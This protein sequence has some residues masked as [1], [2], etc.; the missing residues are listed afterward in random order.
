MFSPDFVF[1]KVTDIQPE[2]LKEKGICALVL[3]VDNTLSIHGSQTPFEGVQ[4]WIV[5][6]KNADISLILASNNFKRRVSP[7]ARRLGLNFISMSCKPFS[8]GI[9]KALKNFGFQKSEVAIVGDQIYTDILGGN[10]AGIHSILVQPIE[11][12]R[13]I[14]FRIKR[15]M[16][17]PVIACYYHKK[18]TGG[19]EK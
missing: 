12:E 19:E 17:R 4:D 1:E 8:L 7:F 2:F 3:D 15:I 14:L 10:L 13:G 5:G 11:A 9:S 18:K 16:E 6:M